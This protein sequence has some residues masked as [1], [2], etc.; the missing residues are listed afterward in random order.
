MKLIVSIAMAAMTVVSCSSVHEAYRT[1]TEI[2]GTKVLIGRFSRTV[3]EKDSSFQWFHTGYDRYTPETIPLKFLAGRSS[4]LRFVLFIGTWCSDS[5]AEVPKMFKV[6]DA[7]NVSS[8][9]IELYGVDRMKKCDDDAQ[10]AYAIINVP[11]LIVYAGK[12]EIG[13]IVEQPREVVESD[14]VSML[15]TVR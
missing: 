15:R 6:F 8:D 7:L 10:A 11:T 12:K 4:E 13:R 14:I 5:K 1:E 9:R 3:L 2:T